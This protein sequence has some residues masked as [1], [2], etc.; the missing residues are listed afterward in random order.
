L[1]GGKKTPEI[2]A[3]LET[4]V[5]QETGGDPMSEKKWVR[6]TLR[7]LSRALQQLGNQVGRTTV[8]RLLKQ[9]NYSLK[10][11]R[12]KLTGV[13]HPDRDRQFKYIRRV[14]KLFIRAGYPVISVDT[15][16]KE[17]IGNFHK[18]GCTWCRQATEVNAHDFP[19]DALVRAVP[20]G[21]YDL[22]HNLGYVYVGTSADT[23]EFAVDAIC[24]S[25]Q[26]FAIATWWKWSQRPTFPQENKLLIL[27][28]AGGSN[29]YRF[30]LWKK[31]IQEC[32]ADALGLEVMVCHYPTGAS[33][34]NPIEHRLFSYISLNWAGQPL[35]S[36][37]KM[38]GYIRG[39]TTESGL[40]VEA[41]LVEGEYE[42]GLKVSDAEIADFNLVRRRVCPQWNYLLRPRRA[43]P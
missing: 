23:S 26:R 19:E 37:D 7:Q 36:L 31:Q 28:D 42:K 14:K 9:Q 3:K 25:Q 12:K 4:L 41:A 6:R 35:H 21:I 11:N 40:K 29:G 32:L 27:C 22:R 24:A 5:E 38:L 1:V 15:K 34:W 16:K 39:T 30:R 10:T 18:P 43:S 20:Y 13:P 33:K 17:L 2:E 8:G